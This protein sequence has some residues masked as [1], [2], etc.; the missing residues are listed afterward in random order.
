MDQRNDSN[1]NIYVVIAVVSAVILICVVLVGM[2]DGVW[3]WEPGSGIINQWFDPDFGKDEETTASTEDTTQSDTTET[4]ESEENEG[5][6]NKKPSK[7]SNN[8]NNDVEY[9][10]PTIGLEVGGTENT[11]P[12]DGTGA[13]D[14]T[15]A[16]ENTQGEDKPRPEV[17]ENGNPGISFDDL[18]N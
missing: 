9:E 6:G 5:S 8:N 2:I 7:P 15:D 4:T 16:T 10:E 12:S 3:P 1:K 11:T 13:E 18:W 14:P 17:D